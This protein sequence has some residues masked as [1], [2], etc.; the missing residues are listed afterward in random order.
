[1][2]DKRVLV[3][4]LLALI[5]ILVLGC[6]TPARNTLFQTST[7]DAL[8]LGVYDGD[9][10][11]RHLLKH[12]DF[13]IGTFDRLDGEMV[14]L[15]GTIYQIKADGKV[16]KPDPNSKTPF[17]T[18][19]HFNPEKIISINTSMDYK[20]L[21]K[22]IDAAAPNRNHFCAIKV[23]GQ[24]RSM[25]TRSVPAQ[26]RP[27]PPLKEVTGN[28]PEFEINNVFGT[29]VGFRC[30]PYV[31]GINVPGYHLHF[32]SKD[33]TQGGHVLGFQITN[34]QCEIHILNKYFLMLPGN[35]DFA[36]ADL[37]RDQ[38]KDLI[39]VEKGK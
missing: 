8:L 33:R 6:G 11:C 17:A 27:Y 26:E 12:G 18:T 38:D 19:C 34:G 1:M 13:G 25:R 5:L 29:I 15:D 23:T 9:I 36:E 32:I 39:D 7:I 2:S 22:Q 28:Q 35:K 14:I 24:F 4:I 16:Y 3:H 21:E 37:S 10:T 31:K 20:G 30:P